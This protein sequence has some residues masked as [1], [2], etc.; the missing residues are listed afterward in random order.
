MSCDFSHK[1]QISDMTGTW[2]KVDVKPKSNVSNA[3]LPD[4]N[5]DDPEMDSD[6]ICMQ[7]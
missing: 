6:C 4:P 3:K 2:K 7:N 1:C 5:E